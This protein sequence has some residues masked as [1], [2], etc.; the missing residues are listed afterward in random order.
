MNQARKMH[1]VDNA[2]EDAAFEQLH[3]AL[4]GLENEISASSDLTVRPE[5]PP[6]PPVKNP[7]SDP[8]EVRISNRIMA[9]ET[10][11]EVNETRMKQL[12]L[13]HTE[14]QAQRR[15]EL[16]DFRR[17]MRLEEERLIRRMEDA[18]HTLAKEINCAERIIA[19]DT[20]GLEELRPSPLKQPALPASED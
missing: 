17:Q 8:P 7:Y 19:S 20:R 11:I 13:E 10:E 14:A 9:L 5:T 12:R 16:D 4:K 3:T 18:E 6:S 2:E 15:A 1:L